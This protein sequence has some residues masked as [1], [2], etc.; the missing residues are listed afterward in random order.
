MH[1]DWLGNTRLLE[2]SQNIFPKLHVPAN[3]TLTLMVQCGLGSEH[4][5]GGR[6]I[7][8]FLA[9]LQFLAWLLLR[10][11]TKRNNKI[12]MFSGLLR[13][14]ITQIKTEVSA[15]W[16]TTENKE[17]LCIWS[18]CS[19]SAQRCLLP[20][21]RAFRNTAN[22]HSVLP[23]ITHVPTVNTNDWVQCRVKKARPDFVL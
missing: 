8:L 18:S 6:V 9:F 12:C 17:L 13:K 7:D 14:K 10:D 22:S 1:S 3:K 23:V 19:H 2:D 4:R 16:V 15:A 21:A 20:S 5:S 11:V